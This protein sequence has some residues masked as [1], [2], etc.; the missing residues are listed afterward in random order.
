MIPFDVFIKQR[1]PDLKRIARATRGEFDYSD[2]VS[3]AWLMAKRLSAGSTVQ[4]GL[5]DVPFQDRVISHLYQALV[6]YTDR[7]VRF[8]M[9]I[10]HGSEGDDGASP[11][12]VALTL[13]SDDGRDPLAELLLNEE[14]AMHSACAA[15]DSSVMGAWMMLLSRYDFRMKAVAE[16]LLISVSHA[17]RCRARARE[18]VQ[19]QTAIPLVPPSNASCIGPWRRYRLA[20]A[21][22]QLE[23]FVDQ[24]GGLLGGAD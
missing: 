19:R 21:P 22:L 2:V 15:L 24:A 16:R 14:N 9:R 13:V 18:I 6:H 3:E 1:E 4:E 5:A 10:D 17:Y 8:A 7:T 20:R 12:P 11:H 23:L